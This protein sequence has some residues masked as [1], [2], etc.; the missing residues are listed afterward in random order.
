VAETKDKMVELLDGLTERFGDE[1]IADLAMHV[2]GCP[3]ACAQ[4]WVGEIGLQ[5]TT[6]DDASGTR[7]Q[8]YDLSVGGGLGRRTAIGR[9][10]LRRV[11]TSEVGAV[12]E[13]LVGAWVDARATGATVPGAT[14]GDF[15]DGFDD[16]DLVAIAVGGAT[17]D[18]EPDVVGVTVLV[19]GPLQTWTDGADELVVPG[20]TVGEVLTELS[21][22]HP[23]LGAAVLPDGAVAGSFLVTVADDDIR[24]REGLAT[25]V[26]PGDVITIVMAMAG[27]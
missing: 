21:A 17:A 14:L 5:G 20:G 10:L 11:P 4:H 24:N 12:L 27:G 13:R 19:P 16:E 9:R 22:R 26:A 25:A 23:G 7:V 8:A 15:V 3:H 18:G 6:T 2:D 1:A